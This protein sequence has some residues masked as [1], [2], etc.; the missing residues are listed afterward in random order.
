MRTGFIKSSVIILGAIL[1]VFILVFAIAMQFES[2]RFIYISDVPEDSGGSL[3]VTV[4]SPEI[5]LRHCGYG[6]S[7]SVVDTNGEPIVNALVSVRTEVGLRKSQTNENG[8]FSTSVHWSCGEPENFTLSVTKNGYQSVR[9]SFEE[10]PQYGL[11]IE[12][13]D[14]F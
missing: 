1:V 14:D 7:G 2:N 10:S 13:R 3:F 4:E 5:V 6:A 8:G 9:L 12:L 11:R